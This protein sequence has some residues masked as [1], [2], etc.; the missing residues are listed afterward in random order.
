MTLSAVIPEATKTRLHFAVLSK[1]ELLRELEQVDRTISATYRL[2]GKV[3]TTL[4]V[5][6]ATVLHFMR[7]EG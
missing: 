5:L 2:T 4:L 1:A 3:P 7:R 6:R